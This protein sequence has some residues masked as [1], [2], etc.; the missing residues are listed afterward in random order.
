MSLTNQA[1]G[2][3]AAA[4]PSGD[5]RQTNLKDGILS[6]LGTNI[7]TGTPVKMN[8]DGTIIPCTAAANEP[9][10]GIFAGCEFS[11]LQRRFVLPYFPAGQTYD[12]GSMIAKVV[13]I[14]QEALFIG[15]TNASVLLINRGEG[16]NIAQVSQGSTFTGLS[17]QQFGAPVGA[18]AASYT[19]YDVVQ[20]PD[21]DW[22]D[23]FVW[24]YVRIQNKMGPVA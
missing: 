16:I 17:S 14:D 11:A 8:T 12:L 13:P 5:V 3:I 23:P 15:Q 20:Q 18:T 4:H 7:F 22:G 24:I 6:G 21:N 9:V 2:L 19:I 1:Q 10:Y